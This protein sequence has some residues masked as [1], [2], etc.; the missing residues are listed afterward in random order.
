MTIESI[1]KSPRHAGR[2]HLINHIHGKRLTQR[3]CIQ[4]KCYECMNGYR[5]GAVDC[6]IP[7]CPLYPLMPYRSKT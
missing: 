6:R 4:A 2:R 1:K 7:D 5:D 3:Q